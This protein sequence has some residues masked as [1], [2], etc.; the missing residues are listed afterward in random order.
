MCLDNNDF[1]KQSRSFLDKSTQEKNRYYLVLA[2]GFANSFLDTFGNML[3][4]NAKTIDI[5][6]IFYRKDGVPDIILFK[7][8]DGQYNYELDQYIKISS[9]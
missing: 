7:L 6:K 5:V 1:Y 8:K 2:Q 9:E 3:T 4:R